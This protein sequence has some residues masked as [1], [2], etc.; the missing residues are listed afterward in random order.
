ERS[1]VLV[2]VPKSAAVGWI[3]CQ[4]GV[5]TPPADWRKEKGDVLGALSGEHLRFALGQI[6]QRIASQ[7]AS[8]SDGGKSYLRRSAVA[9]GNVAH[10]AIER[11]HWREGALLKDGR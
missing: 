1:K 6:I 5:I 11:I 2:H 10:P 9:H 3:N 7:P 8:I 4:G